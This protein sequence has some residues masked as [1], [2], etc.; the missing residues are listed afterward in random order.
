LK[1][2]IVAID[3]LRGA[4][5]NGS[6]T[7]KLEARSEARLT[8]GMRLRDFV[9]KTV[10]DVK[11]FTLRG[12]MLEGEDKTLRVTTLDGRKGKPITHESV[13]DKPVFLSTFAPLPLMLRGDPKI[14]DSIS[15]G[16]Y[17]PLSRT[18]E[19]V[20]LRIEADSLFLVPDSAKMDSASGRWVKEHQSSIRGW[21]V[22]GSPPLQKVWVDA[23]GRI[24]Y[25]EEPGGFSFVRTTYELS[26]ANWKLDHMNAADS[27]RARAVA[28]LEASGKNRE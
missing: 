2:R 1:D 23:S 10:G 6:D 18:V 19:P 24:L 5:P 7:I 11:P 14:G 22:G 21:R 16:V 25:A 26:F 4:I 3:F 9:V 20:T 27:A 15:V 17:N 13:P 8:R 28:A 12:V